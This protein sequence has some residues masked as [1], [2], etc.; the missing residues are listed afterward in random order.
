MTAEKRTFGDDWMTS[1]VVNEGRDGGVRRGEHVGMYQ[2]NNK[3][4]RV[5]RADVCPL[6]CG[7]VLQHALDELGSPYT[8][9]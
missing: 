9:H 7:L 3:F 1:E 8:I 6:F 5:Q 2:S 4:S